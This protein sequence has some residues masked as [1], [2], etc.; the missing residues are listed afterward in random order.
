[1]KDTPNPLWRRGAVTLSGS[2]SPWFYHVRWPILVPALIVTGLLPLSIHVLMLNAGIPHPKPIADAGLVAWTNDLF[3]AAGALLV[4]C[5]IGPGLNQRSTLF[6]AAVVLLLVA[7]L[8]GHVFRDAFMDVYIVVAPLVS[9][10]T[11]ALLIDDYRPVLPMA[12]TVLLAAFAASRTR[13][14]L[15]ISVAAVAIS[16]VVWLVVGQGLDPV[17]DPINASLDAHEGRPFEFPPYDARI[18]IPAYATYLEPAIASVVLVSLLW[19][20][21]PPHATRRIGTAVAI[22]FLLVG[23]VA[24]PFIDAVR[25]PDHLAG[26][27]GPMQ[28]SFETMA[29]GLLAT[30]SR[31]VGVRRVS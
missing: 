6:R 12:L 3:T 7:A 13:G 31:W 28:F 27:L 8:S 1:M 15:R 10:S 14:V 4:F 5:C 26:F 22:I 21:L 19:D 30:L 18:Q 23:P 29:L 20:R 24:R 17:L 11:L 16:L 25:D 2:G 9:L